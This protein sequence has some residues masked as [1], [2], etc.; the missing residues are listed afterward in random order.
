MHLRE[1]TVSDNFNFANSL[2]QDHNLTMYLSKWKKKTPAGGCQVQ[3]Q[4]KAGRQ[5][6]RKG[7]ETTRQ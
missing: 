6:K 5:I 3:W 2:L 7:M 4:H 1:I